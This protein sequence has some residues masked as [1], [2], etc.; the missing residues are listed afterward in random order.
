MAKSNNKISISSLDRVIKESFASTNIA[1]WHGLD[2]SIKYNLSFTEMLEFV[3]DVV[4]SCFQSN[5]GFMPEVMNFAIRSNILSKYTNL[6]LP[7]RLEHR[8]E[9]V[10]NS[11]VVDFVSEYI[12]IDQLREITSSIDRK[13][14][15]LCNANVMNIQKQMT[16]LLS[17][18]EDV[19]QKTSDMF[20]NFTPDDLTKIMGAL[21]GGGLNEEKIVRAYLE[22]T[23]P[24]EAEVASDGER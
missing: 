5:G 22:Q 12:D 11:D 7:D 2:I 17:A 23:T 8:Y 6:S 18:F 13:I 24:A 10:Y 3:N 16:K 9:I 19:Q 21:D 20:A 15:Y 4:M 1:E 14:S